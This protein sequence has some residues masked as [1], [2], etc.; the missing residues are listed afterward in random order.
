MN[1]LERNI[2]LKTFKHSGDLGDIIFSIPTIRALAG[3]NGGILFLDPEGGESSPLV[4]WADRKKTKLNIDAIN[5]IKFFL[6]SQEGIRHVR[7]WHGEK[8]DYDLD[9]FRNNIKYNN[10][11]IS[12]LAA[13]GLDPSLSSQKW[14]DFKNTR[15]LPKKIIINRSV[16]YHGHFSFW[17]HTLP[18]IK[19]DSIFVGLPKD[20]EIF[21]YT[22]G[23]KL[24][25]YP[26]PTLNDLIET[27]N[28]C[29]LIYCN[30]GL[31]HALAEGF[32][33]N[34]ICEVY[35]VYPAAVF[36][37]KPTSKYI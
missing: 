22:F 36:K 18:K 19:N 8:V 29:D 12:H 26:T 25:Y 11:A 16:R 2:T 28:S 33:K 27:I 9:L 13:F 32:H 34:L 21:N 14:L 35:R 20:Y 1:F 6:E 15:E 30:Q 3:N 31:P 17:E 23:H 24:E 10:L 5:Q 4:K 37:N 7:P